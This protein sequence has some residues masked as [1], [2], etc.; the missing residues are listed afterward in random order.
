[1][2]ALGVAMGVG[3]LLVLGLG[4]QQWESGVISL[5]SGVALNEVQIW[6]QPT[7]AIEAWKNYQNHAAFLHEDTR[8]QVR[9]AQ[10]FHF[11]PVVTPVCFGIEGTF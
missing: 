5:V 10:A 3:S 9:T 2:H 8:A 4:F 7:G 1:M 11:H 6:T